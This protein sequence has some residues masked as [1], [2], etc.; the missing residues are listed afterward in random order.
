M[1]SFEPPITDGK[2]TPPIAAPP[3]ADA[4]P[5]AAGAAADDAASDEDSLSSEVSRRGGEHALTSEALR[6]AVDGAVDVDEEADDVNAPGDVEVL[7]ND[8]NET[9]P[10]ERT[11]RT[12]FLAKTIGIDV[13]TDLAP[14][15]QK[16]GEKSITITKKMILQEI[17]RRDPRIKIKNKKNT[18]NE[19]LMAVLPDLTDARDVAYIRTQYAMIRDNLLK[20]VTVDAPSVQRKG[21]VI[22]RVFLLINM[23]PDLRRAY[24]LSQTGSNREMLDA[25][26]THMSKFLQLLVCYFNDHS[27]EVSTPCQPS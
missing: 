16:N 2:D 3:I 6:R 21:T 24:S 8:D 5:V 1:P 19:S 27:L 22:M 12:L 14:F 17:K 4:P 23:L 9:P 15:L 18:T 10:K 26:E 7:L 11:K 20:G 25:G 13:D